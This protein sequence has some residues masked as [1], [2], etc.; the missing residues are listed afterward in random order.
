MKE[1]QKDRGLKRAAKQQPRFSLPTNF[2]Y[3]TM[4]KVDETALLHER[5]SERCML[6]ATI[7]AS[8]CLIVDCVHCISTYFGDTFR[9][10]FSLKS[11]QCIHIDTS[12]LPTYIFFIAIVTIL[13]FLDHWMRKEYFKRHGGN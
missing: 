9:E 13:L 3:R 8:V 5:R 12:F 2:V 10:A 6:W 7:A 11:L 1:E 4:Q